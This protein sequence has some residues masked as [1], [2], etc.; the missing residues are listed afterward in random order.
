MYWVTE[1]VV[2]KANWANEWVNVWINQ[3]MSMWENHWAKKLVAWMRLCESAWPAIVYW[4]PYM[5]YHGLTLGL[6]RLWNAA[7]PATRRSVWV[8]RTLASQFACFS[9][10][11]ICVRSLN[12]ESPVLKVLK[13]W[14]M[15]G[16]NFDSQVSQVPGI[17][18]WKRLKVPGH[19]FEIVYFVKSW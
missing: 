4:R 14:S 10:L 7:T 19:S 8:W 6:G 12:P 16:G 9:A 3:D 15:C 5:D 17:R 1:S 2:H 11:V 18:K 13:C